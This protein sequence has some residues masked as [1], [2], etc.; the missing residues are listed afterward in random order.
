M[1]FTLSRAEPVKREIRELVVHCSATPGD[2]PLRIVDVRR[3][4]TAPKPKGNGWSDVGYHFFIGLDGLVETGRALSVA[5]AHVAGHNSTSIGICLAGGVDSKN[6]PLDTF[7]VEQYDALESLLR[8][9]RLRFP[10]ARIMG[11]RDFPGVNKACPSFDVAAWCR[12]VGI[13]AR[14]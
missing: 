6:R 13:K 5:G 14:P 2:K 9:L 1:A 7:T 11:H 3:W 4:H 10:R 12:S 8:E